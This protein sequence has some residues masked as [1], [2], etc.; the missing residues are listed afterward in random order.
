MA[1][2]RARAGGAGIAATGPER[3]RRIDGASRQLQALASHAR[4]G[5][6][7]ARPDGTVGSASPSRPARAILP[8][9]VAIATRAAPRPRHGHQPRGARDAGLR[10]VDATPGP[11]SRG[12]APAGGS[13]TA[14]PTAR[15]SATATTLARIRALAIP[16]AWTDVW[17]CPDPNGHLQATGRDARGRKQYRYHARWRERARR[18]RSSTGCSPSPRRCRAI[19]ERVDADL[20]RPGLPR[21][22][23]LA[24]VVRLL[25]L[26]LIRVGNDEYA[27]LNRSFGLTTLR[28][29]HATVDGSPI[30]FRFRGKSRP[31]STRSTLRDRRLARVVAAL[32]GPARPGALPVRRRG[33]RGP[34]RPLRRRQR[35]P[36]RGRRAATS[37]PRTSGP[38]PG[39]CSRTARCARS[40][41]ATT[42]RE[43]RRN[44]VEAIRQTAE[45]LGNTP[46]VARRQLRPPGRPR[47]VPRRRR[48]AARSSRRPRSRRRRPPG[49][50][51]AEEAGVVALLRAA[52][53]PRRDA[54]EG[55]CGAPGRPLATER[56]PRRERRHGCRRPD[57]RGA[58]R[59]PGG[60]H[61]D[62]VHRPVSS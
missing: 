11:G 25:E 38:G 5:I 49:R 29:R 7:A 26:T 48:S 14:T 33:R 34:R 43:A 21:E 13:P 16:P 46:A 1:V 61:R 10:Y 60:R 56:G 24:A 54:V 58:A 32:P 19:R 23:V 12:G 55:S 53:G 37:R 44:V 57:V 20:G 47:G 45:P 41:P 30:R 18:R 4:A 28:D 6:A 59:S 35:L 2:G 36:A 3:R 22:K 8:T 27:R 9:L 51:P 62:P 39:R 50:P 17:I 15:R 40:S 52:A 31:A 42:D